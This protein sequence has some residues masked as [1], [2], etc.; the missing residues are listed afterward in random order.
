MGR[1]AP[2]RCAPGSRAPEPGVPRPMPRAGPGHRVPRALTASVP[3]TRSAAGRRGTGRPWAT[4]ARTRQCGGCPSGL[5]DSARCVPRRWSEGSE[6]SDQT[7]LSSQPKVVARPGGQ[8]WTPP[9]R[10]PSGPT[11][12]AKNSGHGQMSHLCL[13]SLSTTPSLRTA[14]EHRVAPEP[15]S[16]L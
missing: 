13:R 5:R 15:Q 4:G 14:G 16:A 6:G 11:V 1:G 12:P 2:R 10:A 7:P 8:P 9:R 3:W